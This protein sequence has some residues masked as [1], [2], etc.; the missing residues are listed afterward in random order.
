[1]RISILLLI[2]IASVPGAA[3]ECIVVEGDQILAGDLARTLPVFSALNADL[4]LAY[5]PVVGVDRVMRVAEIERLAER[6]SLPDVEPDAVCFERAS[7]L[8]T[9]ERVEAALRGALANP[10]ATMEL[11]DFSRQPVP[12]GELDFQIAGLSS[13]GKSEPDEPMLWRGAVRYSDRRSVPVWARVRILVPRRQ[14]VAIH[15]LPSGEPI[16][17]EDIEERVVE[18][19]PAN[20]PPLSNVSDALGS[21]PRRSIRAGESVYARQL[22]VPDDVKR[23]ETVSVTVISGA[24][25]LQFD[26]RAET[27]GRRGDSVVVRNPANGVK[28]EAEVVGRC[29]VLV[30]AGNSG[31]SL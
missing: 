22:R 24:A 13:P 14:V 6:Y 2:L 1:M 26:A 25:R 7:E 29:Q 20:E 16:E 3:G 11:I 10:D 18:A 5:S 8:L 27:T 23:G 30:R 31:E 28:F 15:D 21:L 9:T 4:P 19:F 12:I 17:I